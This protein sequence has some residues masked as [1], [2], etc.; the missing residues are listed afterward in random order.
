MVYPLECRSE[1]YCTRL[2]GN[3]GPKKSSK[4]HYLGT[5]A[6][7]CRQCPRNEG[8]DNRKKLVKYNASPTCPRNMVNFGTLAAEICW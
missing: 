8:I 7:P 2:A 6:Q 5:I 3:A 4:I 1:M